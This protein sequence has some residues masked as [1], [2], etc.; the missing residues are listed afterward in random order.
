MSTETCTI[1]MLPQDQWIPAANQA[2]AINP[3]NAR[4]PAT[5]KQALRGVVIPPEHLALLTSKYWGRGGVRLTVA[6]LDNLRLIFERASS[7]T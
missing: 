5:L 3:A 4:S 6:F 7:A 2:L 1:K